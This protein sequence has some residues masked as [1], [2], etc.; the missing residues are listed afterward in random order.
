MWTVRSANCHILTVQRTDVLRTCVVMN[1][2]VNRI[3][4]YLR[5]CTHVTKFP[6]ACG[7]AIPD[8]RSDKIFRNWPR[9]FIGEESHR[10]CPVLSGSDCSAAQTRNPNAGQRQRSEI[11]RAAPTATE[12]AGT[13]G[14][15]ILTDRLGYPLIAESSLACGGGAS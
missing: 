13:L 15:G 11:S 3:G 8:P 12:P 4:V 1:K 7:F 2:S 9:L 14:C 5:Q 10:C 6:F